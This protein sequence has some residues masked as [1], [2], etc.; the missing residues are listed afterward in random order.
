MKSGSVLLGGLIAGL[1]I[2]LVVADHP[3]GGFDPIAPPPGSSP[4]PR[5]STSSAVRTAVPPPPVADNPAPA[6][7]VSDAVAVLR[8][9]NLLIPVDGVTRQDL[10]DTFDDPRDKTRVHEALDILAP[11][12]TPVFAAE[13][14]TIEKLFTSVKG[15]LTVYQFDPASTYC[16][17]YAHLDHYRP[18]LKEHERVARGDVIG[19]VGTT[20]NAPK[21]TPH[22]HFGIFLLTDKKEWWTGTALNPYDVWGR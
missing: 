16:Y 8:G 12:G 4:A 18:G 9:R 2:I 17:Y 6:A 13:A 3:Q 14:G 21:N 11:R 10:Q 15:G 5:P 1:V 20:G 7:S 22:L 19:F